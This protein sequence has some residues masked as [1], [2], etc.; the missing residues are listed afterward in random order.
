MLITNGKIVTPN[1][2]LEDHALVTADGVIQAIGR[3]SD[4]A[5][6]YPTAERIDARGQYVMPG[7][8]C[9]HTH[10]Y[11]AYARGMAIPGD[12]PRDFPEILSRLWWNLDKALDQDAVRMS[13]LVCLVDAIKHGTTTLIDHHA[14]PNCI[15]GSL[16]W[17]ADAVDQAGLRAVLCYE[18]TDRD[19]RE[20]AEAGIAENIR[21]MQSERERVRGT[22]G[23]HAS[24]T[25]SDET[26]R[27]CADANVR[28]GFHVHVAEHEADEL[29]SLTKAGKRVVH[30]L[31][32]F[33]MLGERTITAHCVHTHESERQL[34]RE[35]GTWVTHQPRSNMNNAV[36]AMAWDTMVGEEIKLCL[37]NDGFSN[38]MWEDWKAAYLLH[39]VVSRDPRQ[40][41]GGTIWQAAVVNNARLVE[42]FFPN[43]SIGQLIEGAR[44]DMIFVDYHPFTPLTIGNMPWHIL[45]GFESSMVTTTIV[46]GRI[47][48]R[49]R[50]L[51]TLDERAIA[52]EALTIAP[53]VW[54]RYAAYAR[55]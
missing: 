6:R 32:D 41:N 7:N 29:D 20:K 13:A 40:A 26:L 52:R 33:G 12:P 25:L 10:F 30:R 19:G 18:V 28:G 51:I 45:F 2:I 42:T 50:Q 16:D 21:F 8:I 37:G 23:L 31:H 39:K 4:L 22:F 5:E 1:E 49:D 47:L 17:I 11:G 53:G 9:A 43:Y 24:L 55:R 3:A 54:E 15:D 48:M 35:T 46:D 36:G 27:V 38:A 14:S 34:L 44:A